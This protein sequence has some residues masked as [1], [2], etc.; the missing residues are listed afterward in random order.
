MILFKYNNSK[1]KKNM[2]IYY[3]YHNSKINI[4]FNYIHEGFWVK[5]FIIILLFILSLLNKSYLNIIYL[6]L[7]LH[8][9]VT[10]VSTKSKFFN[11]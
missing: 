9:N 4:V 10:I 2:K 3:P 5:L 6:Y 1:D 7:Y 8:E 11:I